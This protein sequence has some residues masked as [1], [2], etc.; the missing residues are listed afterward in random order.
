M[1]PTP[2]PSS[3][4]A[5][6]AA[7]FNK[8]IELKPDFAEAY[9]ER[10]IAKQA[11]GDFDG[12]LTDYSKAIELKPDAFLAYEHR[13]KLR[14]AKGDAAGAQEDANKAAELRTR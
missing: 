13:S 3:R 1:S 10:G 9:Y 6:P 4:P 12:A 11:K 14:K 7:Q 5:A 8:A 2:T